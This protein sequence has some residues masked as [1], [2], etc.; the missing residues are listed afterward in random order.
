MRTGLHYGEMDATLVF[1]KERKNKTGRF[2]PRSPPPTRK[3]SYVTPGLTDLPARVSRVY[4]ERWQRHRRPILQY[5]VEE[6]FQTWDIAQQERGRKR[7]KD[8]SSHAQG[9]RFSYLENRVL[10]CLDVDCECA[11]CQGRES[12][13]EYGERIRRERRQQEDQAAAD[14]GEE[15]GQEPEGYYQLVHLQYHGKAASEE[16]FL[17][18]DREGGQVAVRRFAPGLAPITY[19]FSAFQAL[20]TILTPDVI[21]VLAPNMPPLHCRLWNEP[22]WT[23]CGAPNDP[24]S[25]TKTTASWT[26]CGSP[27]KR[28]CF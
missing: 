16:L 25:M 4:Q 28:G 13:V 20:T 7:K 9:P 2:R 14:P 22:T 21:F 12:T 17:A 27:K 8:N 19:H 23:S 3:P 18:H 1:W 26:R 10:E 15:N 6:R 5:V 24:T 11:L